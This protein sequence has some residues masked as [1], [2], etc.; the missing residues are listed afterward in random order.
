MKKSTNANRKVTEDLPDSAK[1]KKEMKSE[2]TNIELPD[3]K[4]I[5]GQEN[6]VPLPFG[7]L[8]DNTIAS[9]D[10]EADNLFNEDEIEDEDSNVS[11]AEKNDLEASAND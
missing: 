4:D 5:P 11:S 2:T 7:E 1:D 3:V 6:I 10:E 9:A 8:A